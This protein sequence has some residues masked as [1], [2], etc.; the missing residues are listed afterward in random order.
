[1]AEHTFKAKL[2]RW[3]RR[4]A[5]HDEALLVSDLPEHLQDK[6]YDSRIVLRLLSYVRPYMREMIIAI[7]LIGVVT[8]AALAVPYIIAQILDKAIAKGDVALLL[9]LVAAFVG[10]NLISWFARSGQIVAMVGAGQDSIY[11]I[12]RALFKRL[13]Q[14]SLSFFDHADVGVL[15]SRLTSDVNALQDLVTWAVIGTAADM[16]TLIGIV[17]AM[18]SLDVY[19]SLLTFAVLPIMFV[20]TL[21]WRVRA[22]NRWR[23]VR[24]YHGRML[25]YIEENIQGVRVVQAYTREDLNLKKFVEEVNFRF[26][27]AQG[28]A[29]RLSA[30]FFPGVDFLGSLAIALVIGFGG[31]AVLGQQITPGVLVAFTLYI[32][33]FFDPIRDLAERYNTLQ[34]AMAAGE[35]LFNLLDR[36]LAVESKPGAPEMPPI[37]GEV[38][39]EHVNFA[40]NPELPILHDI[41]LH[42]RPGELVAL[43]GPTGSGK[44]SLV[45]LLNRSYDI[46]SGRLLIDGHD[47]R[48][49]DLASQRRQ[50]G[51]V[52]QETFLFRGSVAEN[53]RYGRLDAT[54]TEIE[55]AARAVGAHE[56]IVNLID[57]YETHVEEGGAN[58]S[59]GQ[60]Q[61]LA[62]ARALLADP[63]ILILDEATSSIDTQTEKLIQ[64][65]MDVL[66]EGRTAFVIAHRLSTIVRADQILVLSGGRIIER[67]THEELLAQR[68]EYYNLYTMGFMAVPLDEGVA[69]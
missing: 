17:I 1:M 6:Q 29:A 59:V 24:Y 31:T 20:L 49:V 52:L 28:N 22:R 35:R 46:Q 51:I 25:G 7:I 63:R 23:K 65:A 57:G 19:L 30:L 50:M 32:G 8:L 45:K 9:R 47:V 3:W 21:L 44:S 11:Q 39:F 58:L 27:Q 55:R 41:N 43:V 16:F 15:I 64:D 14:H 56:F 34:A 66:L 60:R 2:H 68:G 67:G 36:P 53:I 62:F 10:V 12:R 48:D 18:L 40:Y 42:V 4:V 26:N 38:V 37:R 33:R 54:Q 5:G 69:G 13:Q 61:L